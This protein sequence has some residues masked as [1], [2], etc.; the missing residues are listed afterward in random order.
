MSDL[1][2]G[3]I[4]KRIDPEL[5]SLCSELIGSKY[6]PFLDPTQVD[7]YTELSIVL[8]FRESCIGNDSEVEIIETNFFDAIWLR[9]QH[10]LIS[11]YSSN[12][13]RQDSDVQSIC[14]IIV[15][16]FIV[17]TQ[18]ITYRHSPATESL[19]D[20]FLQLIA[21]LNL[22][23]L[24]ENFHELMVW[25]FMFV[26]YSCSEQAWRERFL[27]EMAKGGR[28]KMTWEWPEVRKLLLGFFFVDRLQGEEFRKM[29]EEVRLLSGPVSFVKAE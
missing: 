4:S 15:P 18:L 9:A 1:K 19:K 29:C 5:G 6:V 11:F 28:G 12:M 20:Q 25:A 27:L 26:C 10:S 13:F 8:A 22:Q 23:K 3:A 17:H 21:N 14:R 7:T 24:W 2:Y 16:I